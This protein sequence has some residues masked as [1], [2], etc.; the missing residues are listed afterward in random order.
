[1]NQGQSIQQNTNY[2]RSMANLVNYIK[3]II[4]KLTGET[5]EGEIEK[6][7]SNLVIIH[8]NLSNLSTSKVKNDISQE[9]INHK[10]KTVKTDTNTI[11]DEVDEIISSFDKMDKVIA[12]NH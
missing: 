10:D 12:E 4:K 1:M 5:D 7:Y 3:K 9:I 8:G 11:K 2:S 6:L